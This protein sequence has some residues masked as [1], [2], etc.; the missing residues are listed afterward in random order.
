MRCFYMTA[1]GK[2]Q[3]CQAPRDQA[4]RDQ[5]ADHFSHRQFLTFFVN[6][7][8]LTTLEDDTIP[9]GKIALVVDM[10]EGEKLATVDFDNLIIRKP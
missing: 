1:S 2:T 7:V 6:D 8:Q 5:S 9:E 3:D 4:W 10:A